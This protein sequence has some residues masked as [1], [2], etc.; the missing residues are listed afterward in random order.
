MDHKGHVKIGIAFRK[1]PLIVNFLKS[2]KKKHLSIIVIT[3]TTCSKT[4]KTRNEGIHL[5]SQA[6][7]ILFLINYFSTPR[8]S[9]FVH[10]PSILTRSIYCFH[11]IIFFSVCQVTRVA[12]MSTHKRALTTAVRAQNYAIDLTQG[13][14]GWS[15]IRDQL[16]FAMLIQLAIIGDDISVIVRIPHTDPSVGIHADIVVSVANIEAL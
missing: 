14:D 9:D 13:A 5:F 2:P 3:M 12:V 7:G 6:N 4:G 10:F 1:M 11:Y 15:K 16:L 8:T